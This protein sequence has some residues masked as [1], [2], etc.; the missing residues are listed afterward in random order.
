MTDNSI[1]E[2][3]WKTL[4]SLS[5]GV[6]LRL[7]T[8]L[9]TSVVEKIDEKGTSSEL[10]EQMLKKNSGAWATCIAGRWQDDRTTEQI[11]SDIREARTKNREIEL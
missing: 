4:C 11:I 5:D 10:A 8:M 3:Y 1:A 6:K 9:T 7:A 2:S